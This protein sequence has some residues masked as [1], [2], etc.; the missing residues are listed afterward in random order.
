MN[1]F[2]LFCYHLKHHL[3]FFFFYLN[4]MASES[5]RERGKKHKQ[6]K[7]SKHFL[8]FFLCNLWAYFFAKDTTPFTYSYFYFFIILLYA[9]SFFGTQTIGNSW[10]GKLKHKKKVKVFIAHVLR[11]QKWYA[12]RRKF[13]QK[14]S[15]RN[16]QNNYEKVNI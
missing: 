14:L 9:G 10:V 15:E 4:F 13:T 8:I 1:Y 6:C 12:R 16:V 5:S 3:L 11:K 2:S 7:N